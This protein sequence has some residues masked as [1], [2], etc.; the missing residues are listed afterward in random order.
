MVG[1]QVMT[2]NS[3]KIKAGSPEAE[4]RA[5]ADSSKQAASAAAQRLKAA[6]TAR[7]QASLSGKLY[8]CDEQ[9]ALSA[10]VFNEQSR[11]GQIGAALGS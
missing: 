2:A 6:V 11:L 4:S 7:R 8:G 3:P 10:A 1:W 5:S 9:H